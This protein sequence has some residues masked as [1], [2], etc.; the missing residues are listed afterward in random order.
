M[1]EFDG[2]VLKSTPFQEND[3]MVTVISSDRYHSFL[4]RGVMKLESKNAPS[5]IDF[6]KGHYEISKG[7]NGETLRRGSLIESYS[8]IKEDITSLSVLDFIKE[9]TIK[10]TPDSDSYKIYPFLEK[11]LFLLNSGFSSFSVLVTYFAKMLIVS[12]YALNVSSC[13]RSNTKKDIIGLSYSDGGF[14]SKECFDEL[15]DKRL[16]SDELN[17][18]RYIFLVDVDRYGTVNLEEKCNLFSILNILDGFLY[19]VSST[20][21]NSLELIRRVMKK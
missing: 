13:V 19:Y 15:N 20:K 6:V 7:K 17:V 4:A 8:K 1:I 5:V 10:L 21:L 2:I 12:G 18:I 3:K 11:S 16:T 14:V 9:I